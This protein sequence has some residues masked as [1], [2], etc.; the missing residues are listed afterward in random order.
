MADNCPVTETEWALILSDWKRNS[1]LVTIHLRG[2]GVL[3]PGKVSLLP[4]LAFDSAQI[5]A[6]DPH[7]KWTFDLS[8]VAAIVAEA[9]HG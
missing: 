6:F 3:G 5:E 4:G 8:E 2:G 7:R 1:A 9:R